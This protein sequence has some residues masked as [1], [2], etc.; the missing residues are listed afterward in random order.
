[1]VEIKDNILRSTEAWEWGLDTSVRSVSDDCVPTDCVSPP[2][3]CLAPDVPDLS[4]AGR[5]RGPG[6]A[7][8]LSRGHEDPPE[9]G[10][11]PGQAGGQRP[12]QAGSGPGPHPPHRVQ[13]RPHHQGLT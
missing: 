3:V 9:R 4:R 11:G 6:L 1:M 8:G 2:Q 5:G 12:R 10:G 13:V 7:G